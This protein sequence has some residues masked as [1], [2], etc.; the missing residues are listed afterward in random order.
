MEP[1]ATIQA[2]FFILE[3]DDGLA[4][5]LSRDLDVLIASR[6][7]RPAEPTFV[8]ETSP[9]SSPGDSAL[10]TVG[11]LLDLLDAR[12]GA[13]PTLERAEDRE[14][15]DNFS[16]V[17]ELVRRFSREHHAS[18]GVEYAGESVGE[19]MNG[20]PDRELQEGLIDPWRSAVS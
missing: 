13:G 15:H 2:L 18:F 6:S 10:R 9:A 14:Q 8:D 7:W 11:A 17:L 5:Q 3:P 19:I 12:A 1:K 4:S 20:E 16:A